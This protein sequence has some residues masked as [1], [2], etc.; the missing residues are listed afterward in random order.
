MGRPAQME[1]LFLKTWPGGEMQVP[2]LKSWDEGSLDF[3]AHRVKP[4]L[5]IPART[6]E[7][8]IVGLHVKPHQDDFSK[9]D[10][11][12]CLWAS[13]GE[14]FKLPSGE[15]PLFCTYLEGSIPG[16]VALVEGGLKAGIFAQ[17]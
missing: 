14:S 9:E 2:F 5:L 17:L 1:A 6:S 12:R 7:G 10:V 13:R 11:P 8:Y 3:I 16:V 4:A 15:A